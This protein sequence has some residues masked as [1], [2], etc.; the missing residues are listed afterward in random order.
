MAS[1]RYSYFRF[2][3]VVRL[4]SIGLVCVLICATLVRT[5]IADEV[6]TP[7]DALTLTP[8]LVIGEEDGELEFL[9]GRIVDLAVGPDGTIFVADQTAEH[10]RVF[11]PSGE[12][13][14]TIGREG[15][16]PGEFGRLAAISVDEEGYLLA[17]DAS[18]VHIFAPDGKPIQ[19][20][21]TGSGGRGAFSIAR[22]PN[23]TILVTWYDV[24]S[25]RVVHVYAESGD[26][27]SSHAT[28]FAEGKDLDVK[29]EQSQSG[30]FVKY[31]SDA[32][33]LLYAQLNPFE[34]RLYDPEYQLNSTIAGGFRSLDMESLFERKADG[35]VTGLRTQS[36]GASFLADGKIFHATV[37][38][39]FTENPNPYTVVE[40]FER[41]GEAV[42]AI[43]LS[44]KITFRSADHD[45]FV[46]GFAPEPFPQVRKYRLECD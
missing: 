26:R 45:G 42:G 37:N 38:R 31:D 44:E 34:L 9:F 33:T 36:S 16:G 11:A 23:R 22:G 20:F 21:D 15:Q 41:N 19:S 24:W 28:S 10:V 25:E 6:P 17:A 32:G 1:K 29:E 27:I 18:R 5:T 39:D 14:R 3:S 4:V 13:L 2:P 30:G 43:V 8:V 40:V 7:D 12:F 35:Y 46:Y